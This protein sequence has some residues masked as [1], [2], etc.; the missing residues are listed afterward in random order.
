VAVRLRRML[1]S[2]ARRRLGRALT[3]AAV[4]PVVSPASVI[5]D[6]RIDEGVDQVDGQV[7]E[8]EGHGD[9]ED[10]GLDY[11]VVVAVD[12]LGQQPPDAWPGED[13][14]GD[15]GPAQKVPCLQPYDGGDG[16]ECVAQYVA[17]EDRVLGKALGAGGSHV[18]VPH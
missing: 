14:F 13:R 11:R 7:D 4:P 5:A 12:R 18:V 10:A 15:D 2:P 1:S 17:V 8:H 9:D 16:D 3:I 6:P